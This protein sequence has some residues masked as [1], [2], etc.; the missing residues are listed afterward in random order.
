MMDTHCHLLYPGIVERLDSVLSEA[1]AAGVRGFVT[2]GTTTTDSL[3]SAELA[4][5]HRDVWFTAGVH[6]LHS[7]EPQHWPD[8]RA[9]GAHPRCVAWGEL[10]LDNHW[11]QP[12]RDTQRRVLDAQLAHILQWRA[13]GLDKPVVIHCRRAVA[14]LL[15]ILRA[16]G[17]PPERFV[18]HC[19]TEGPDDAR[20]VLEIGRA[21]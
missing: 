14:D 20:A 7:H 11:P 13:E 10:G 15:P 12:P 1:R 16:T 5:K 6:P 2:I 4:D 9:A 8:M 3:Q 18:F 17:L 21:S 19:F